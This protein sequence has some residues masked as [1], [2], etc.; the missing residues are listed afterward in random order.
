MIDFRLK[1]EGFERDVN[2]IRLA[3]FLVTAIADVVIAWLAVFSGP[4]PMR[5]LAISIATMTAG[6]RSRFEQHALGH[7]LGL[8]TDLTR[9]ISRNTGAGTMIDHQP[10][11]VT[12]E[13]L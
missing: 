12:L 1:H 4:Y 9:D 7:F 10:T 6:E 2:V 11:F 5:I 8:P 13:R 3:P